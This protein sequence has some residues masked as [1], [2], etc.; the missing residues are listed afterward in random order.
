[1]PDRF[2]AARAARHSDRG[3]LF[4]LVPTRQRPSHPVVR[5]PR[6]VHCARNHSTTCTGKGRRSPTVPPPSRCAGT[7]PDRRGAVR[8]GGR[9]APCRGRMPSLR[10]RTPGTRRVLHLPVSAGPC[11]CSSVSDPC[12]RGQGAG[13]ALLCRCFTAWSPL[14]NPGS[15]AKA[16]GCGAAGCLSEGVR[17]GEFALVCGRR[18]LHGRARESRGGIGLRRCG[19]AVR[20]PRTTGRANGQARPADLRGWDAPVR[21]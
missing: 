17:N 13:S 2:S 20:K 8:D 10:R 3:Q 7:R 19:V 5:P 9:R 15:W 21:P 4:R 16:R 11:E 6:S 14:S 12:P 18:Y 1:M